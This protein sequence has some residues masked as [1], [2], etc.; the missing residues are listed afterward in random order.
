MLFAKYIQQVVFTT[1]TYLQEAIGMGSTENRLH[2]LSKSTRNISKINLM[3]D[4]RQQE[5][6]IIHCIWVDPIILQDSSRICM[7]NIF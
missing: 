7:K 4:L 3:I 1:V 6:V 5:N 2:Y